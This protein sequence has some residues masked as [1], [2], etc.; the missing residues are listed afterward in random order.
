[1]KL[2]DSYGSLKCLLKNFWF[3]KVKKIYIYKYIYIEYSNVFAVPKWHESSPFKGNS[4]ALK[5]TW[6]FEMPSPFGAVGRA[7][8]LPGYAFGRDFIVAE[9]AVFYSQTMARSLRLR[10]EKKK[11]TPLFNCKSAGDLHLLCKVCYQNNMPAT[12][13]PCRF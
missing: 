11:R 5:K 4:H 3:V 6:P 1:M 2:A 9:R 8:C 12:E 7:D 10:L 13:F